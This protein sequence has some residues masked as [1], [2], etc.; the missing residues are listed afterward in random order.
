[1]LKTRCKAKAA[2]LFDLQAEKKN[3]AGFRHE[4]LQNWSGSCKAL[5]ADITLSVTH[6]LEH[7]DFNAS[8]DFTLYK[9][10]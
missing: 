9:V 2:W 3:H 10:E 4:C 5:E 7:A 8:G 6:H 1:M